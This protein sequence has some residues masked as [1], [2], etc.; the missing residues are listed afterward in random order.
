MLNSKILHYFATIVA[1]GSY[2][3]AAGHLGIAQSALSIAMRKFEDQIGM[4]LLIR[5][6]KDT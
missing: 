1:L 5:S 2:T 4:P 6:S 3:K